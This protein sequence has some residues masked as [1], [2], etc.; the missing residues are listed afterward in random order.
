MT[1]TA[2]R[3]RMPKSE[4]RRLAIFHAGW[5]ACTSWEQRIELAV[6]YL[7]GSSRRDLDP[8]LDQKKSEEPAR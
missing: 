4:R 8:D 1:H 2:R 6:A 5:E 7:C 3:K